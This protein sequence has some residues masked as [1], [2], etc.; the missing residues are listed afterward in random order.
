MPSDF[1]S[2]DEGLF[3]DMETKTLYP[4]CGADV[5]VSCFDLEAEKMQLRRRDGPKIA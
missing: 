1:V 2:V 5:K 4:L 3:C